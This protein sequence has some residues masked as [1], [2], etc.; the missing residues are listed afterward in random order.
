MLFVQ[1]LLCRSLYLQVILARCQQS[2]QLGN[3][4]LQRGICS[5]QGA[6][7]ILIETRDLP[8]KIEGPDS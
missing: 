3:F 1:N 8:T 5:L 7:F 4:L 6:N 2:A